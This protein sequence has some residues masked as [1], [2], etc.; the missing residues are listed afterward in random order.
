MKDMKIQLR[1]TQ[2]IM[3]FNKRSQ[4]MNVILIL[5]SD[6]IMLMQNHC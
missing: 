6:I 3:R 1:S 4:N 5:K 2:D